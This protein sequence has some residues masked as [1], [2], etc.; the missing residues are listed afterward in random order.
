M[1]ALGEPMILISRPDLLGVGQHSPGWFQVKDFGK[2][3]PYHAPMIRQGHQ[4]SWAG[5]H[6]NHYDEF[7]LSAS[8]PRTGSTFVYAYLEAATGVQNA[9]I[10]PEHT[11]PGF[12]GGVRVDNMFSVLK[13]QTDLPSVRVSG[14]YNAVVKTHFPYLGPNG[15]EL[16]ARPNRLLRMVRHPVDAVLGM[17][18]YRHKGQRNAIPDRAFL[19]KEMT[20]YLAFMHYWD[21]VMHTLDTESKI[22]TFLYRY[23]DLCVHTDFVGAKIMDYVG[24]S[25]QEGLSGPVDPK[26]P[27]CNGHIGNRISLLSSSLLE[28]L[29]K[30]SSDIVEK[31]NY[32]ALS[33]EL[34]TMT[35][36]APATRRLRGAGQ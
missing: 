8:Y 25:L 34:R 11:N 23:E 30:Q 36:D 29:L 4:G 35:R 5:D 21:Q 13:R 14:K 33:N 1:E 28:E 15:Q 16:S 31:Y 3:K 2:N 18:A 6:S 32:Q 12:F 27:A 7:I 22:P 19:V 20:K 17:W 10:Y 9:A 26:L 24:L